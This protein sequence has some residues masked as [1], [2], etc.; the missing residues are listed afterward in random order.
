MWKKVLIANRGEIAVRIIRACREAGLQCVTVYSTA[1]KTALHAEIADESVCIGPPSVQDSYLNM[2]ALISACQNTG[3]EALHPGFGF[4]SESAEFAQL[5]IDNGITFIGP[6]PASISMLGDKAR[7]K[8]T[9]KAAGVPVIPG[10]DGA[11]T[12]VEEAKKIA[13]EIGYPVLVK[14]SA[15][16]GGRGIR[17]ID[18]EDQLEEQMSVA[19]EEAKLFF[20]ND[21]V[22]LEKLIVGPHHV[23]IQIIADQMGNTVALGERDCSMQRRNQKV[24]EESPSPLMTP[25]LRK[26]MQEAAVRAAK[27]CGYYNAGTIEFLVDDDRNF[28]FMEMN[29]RLQV[30]HSVTEMM[31]NVDIVKWQIRIA[32]GIPLAFKQEDI[33]IDSCAIECRI[34]AEN[35]SQ[36]FRPSCG[37]ITLPQFPILSN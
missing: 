4:L 24:L 10:S 25:E 14:A 16:G 30:E 1:D 22:Y 21:E 8:E 6:S 20:G 36:N 33:R 13:A 34:N 11:V 19:K 2:N 5:C 17:R 12:S 28:Y 18:R 27:A 31:T 32:A 9:M 7:A 3:A 35:P 15:G 37:K 29:T 26:A 23:E